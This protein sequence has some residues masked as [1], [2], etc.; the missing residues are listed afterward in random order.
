M[1][2]L[3]MNKICETCD[4]RNRLGL[5]KGRDG[6]FKYCFRKVGS[7]SGL[8]ETITPFTSIDELWDNCKWLHWMIKDSLVFDEVDY[9]K[10]GHMVLLLGDYESERD[11]LVRLHPCGYVIK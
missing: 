9:T 2:V 1:E 6:E 11:G 4:T 3:L 10:D 7:L 5:C 8:K